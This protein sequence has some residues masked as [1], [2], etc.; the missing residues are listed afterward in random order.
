MT[1]RVRPLFVSLDT[2]YSDHIVQAHHMAPVVLRVMSEGRRLSRLS[3]L[4][5]FSTLSVARRGAQPARAVFI[6]RI[7]RHQIPWEPRPPRHKLHRTCS[8]TTLSLLEMIGN[9]SLGSHD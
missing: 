3:R 8:R 4:N 5:R 2:S 9:V 1:T 6:G 7:T